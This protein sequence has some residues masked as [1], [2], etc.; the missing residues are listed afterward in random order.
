VEYPLA[1]ETVA[2]PQDRHYRVAI[3]V[4]LVTVR[5]DTVLR[6][7]LVDPTVTFVAQTG[8]SNFRKNYEIGSPVTVGLQWWGYMLGGSYVLYSDEARFVRTKDGWIPQGHR[9]GRFSDDDFKQVLDATR[10]ENLAQGADVIVIGTV[11]RSDYLE[12]A[13]NDGGTNLVMRVE[14]LVDEVVKGD[15]ADTLNVTWAVRGGSKAHRLAPAPRTIE[16][17]KKYI[18]FLQRDDESLELY[19]GVSGIYVVKGSALLFRGT[20]PIAAS[21]G[22]IR[23]SLGRQQ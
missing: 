18:F 15:K 2:D 3:E 22:Q 17:G 23:N 4:T 9:H 19:G 12:V 5:V 1:A 8:W 10:P 13:S 6:G 14:L 7:E 20:S 11:S 21:V 16:D